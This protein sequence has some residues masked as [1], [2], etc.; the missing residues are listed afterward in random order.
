MILIA[1]GYQGDSPIEN[2]V[3]KAVELRGLSKY[4]F[5]EILD[6]FKGEMTTRVTISFMIFV[7]NICY[8]NNKQK[9]GE[10]RKK[11][12]CERKR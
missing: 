5:R 9:K 4:R 11:K 7:I 8:F 6:P 12:S 3:R 10:K 2:A 1:Y